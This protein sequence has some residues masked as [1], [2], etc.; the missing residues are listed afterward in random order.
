MLGSRI[1]YTFFVLC[2]PTSSW[3][4]VIHGYHIMLYS[5]LQGASLEPPYTDIDK[6]HWDSGLFT[7]S[8]KCCL[9]WQALG[10]SSVVY[11]DQLLGAHHTLI[12]YHNIFPTAR[13]CL[14][15]ERPPYVNS[16][17]FDFCGIKPHQ[18]WQMLKP[19][20]LIPWTYAFSVLKCYHQTY[21]DSISQ[22]FKNLRFATLGH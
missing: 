2:I 3:V 11:S 13:W 15:D 22:I 21:N 5:P 16:T 17:K 18:F 9:L 19:P 7:L 10:C 12:S 8:L 6:D 4:L 1:V 20:P 14:W